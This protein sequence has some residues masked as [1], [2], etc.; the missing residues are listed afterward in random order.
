[1]TD[2]GE[3][4]SAWFEFNVVA[5]MLIAT[6]FLNLASV[7]QAPVAMLLF[8][9][10]SLLGVFLIHFGREVFGVKSD[11]ALAAFCTVVIVGF[12]VGAA[13]AKSLGSV[14]GSI[15][16]VAMVFLVLPPI[17]FVARKQMLKQVKK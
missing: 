7:Q 12:F 14:Q 15:P 2:S 10:S 11:K 4:K 5:I 13:L 1:M 17:A 3:K 8:A 6:W 16:L 9:A